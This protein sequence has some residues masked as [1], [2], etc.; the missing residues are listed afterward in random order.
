MRSELIV[1]ALCVF[2][3]APTNAQQ[4][5]LAWRVTQ[6]NPPPQAFPQILAAYDSFRGFLVA[7]D[8]IGHA[9]E[10]NGAT[11]TRVADASFLQCAGA[12]CAMEGQ[13]CDMINTCQVTNPPWGSNH[14]SRGAMAYDRQRRVTVLWD[15]NNGIRE[16]DGQTWELKTPSPSPGFL[17]VPSL[18]Y[19]PV[20]EVIVLF[21][22]FRPGMSGGVSNELWEWDGTNWSQRLSAHSPPAC[23]QAGLAFDEA[24]GRLVLFGGRSI[25]SGSTGF[26]GD[27][28]EWDGADWMQQIPPAGTPVPEARTFHI[29][30][31]DSLRRVTVLVG[32]ISAAGVDF[33]DVWEWDGHR[34]RQ[35]LP[36]P[37]PPP[38]VSPAI[39]SLRSLAAAY[40]DTRHE[41]H[42]LSTLVQFHWSIVHAPTPQV[43]AGPNSLQVVE[44]APVALSVSTVPAIHVEFQWRK[45]GVPIPWAT[46]AGYGMPFAMAADQGVYDVLVSASGHN[47]FPACGVILSAPAMLMVTPNIPGDLNGDGLV[48]K[49]DFADFATMFTGPG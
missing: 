30:A 14:S 25:F 45:D 18:V 27:V 43:S 47:P 41:L 31:Y 32:G 20:R 22:G 46:S 3:A 23:Y 19:D 6:L 40:D 1:A 35:R 13:L 39:G 17:F 37:P 49:L 4:D 36:Q 34:W 8:Y 44:G 26:L 15:I 21:G 24:R 28:W 16:W 33:D 29:L 5:C 7:V 10:W 12:P 11:W 2:L 9:Y 42:L 38:H 48:D